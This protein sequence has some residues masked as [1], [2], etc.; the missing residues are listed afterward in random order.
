MKMKKVAAIILAVTTLCSVIPVQ[1]FAE[2]SVP[3]ESL[4]SEEEVVLTSRETTDT[5]GQCGENVTWTLTGEE[6]DLTLTISGSGYMW[7][8]VDIPYGWEDSISEISTII[9]ED[10]VTR[11]GY[12][13]FYGFANLT[14][15]TI[16]KTVTRIDGDA[17]YSCSSLNTVYYAGTLDEWAMIY[18]DDPL[19]EGVS[20]VYSDPGQVTLH[21][22]SFYT[23]YGTAPE[24]IEVPDGECI[25]VATNYDYSAYNLSDTEGYIF[26]GWS[27]LGEYD[28]YYQDSVYYESV[29]EDVE[30]HAVWTEGWAVEGIIEMGEPVV[31]AG[32]PVGSFH[33][34]YYSWG[35]GVYAEGEISETEAYSVGEEYTI[36]IHLL[37]DGAYYY[38][39]EG[40]N[41]VYLYDM[42]IGS[43]PIEPVS[44]S[45]TE[46]VVEFT[47]LPREKEQVGQVAVEGLSIMEGQQMGDANYASYNCNLGFEYQEG[48]YEADHEYTL[49]LHL[50]PY[51][52]QE[53]AN[54]GQISVMIN[55]EIAE[56]FSYSANEIVV[57]YS[58]TTPALI[59]ISNVELTLNGAVGDEI[60]GPYDTYSL[61]NE[62]IYVG[63]VGILW[64]DELEQ[65]DYYLENTAYPMYASLFANGGYSFSE[66]VT[67][68]V[69][70]QTATIDHDQSDSKHL[71]VTFEFTPEEPVTHEVSFVIAV[72]GVTAPDPI[73]V[74]QGMSLSQYAYANDYMSASELF[75]PECGMGQW[76]NG[77]YYDEEFTEPFDYD[78][79]YVLGDLTLYGSI[80][81]DY[82]SS[83]YT[84]S[85]NANGHGYSL[86]PIEIPGYYSLD[87]L[88][89][90]Y[91][92]IH[93]LA[94][95]YVFAGWSLDPEG[96][97]MLPKWE[98]FSD[99]FQGSHQVTLYAV[100]IDQM[101]EFTVT[102]NENG[103]GSAPASVTVN[104][105]SV[106]NDVIYYNG[107]NLITPGDVAGY[108]FDGWCLDEEGTVGVNGDEVILGNVT[109][110][111]HWIQEV[112]ITYDNM[113]HGETPDP[114]YTVPGWGWSLPSLNEDGYYFAGWYRWI[115]G[116]KVCD[117][118]Q[119]FWN[120]IYEDVTFY[121]EWYEIGD[122]VHVT[123][124]SDGHSGAPEDFDI[125]R[126]M[127]LYDYSGWDWSAYQ[128]EDD[129]ENGWVFDGW[130]EDSS[131]EYGD[132]SYSARVREDI[133]LYA[134]WREADP[135][136]WSLDSWTGYDNWEYY[137]GSPLT[138][139][140][141]FRYGDDRVCVTNVAFAED[142][143]DEVF[144]AGKTYALLI[145]MEPISDYYS[146]VTGAENEFS[147]WWGT[148]VE[149]DA[150]HVVVR[151]EFEPYYVSPESVSLDAI[152]LVLSVGD[153]YSL[154]ATVYPEVARYDSISWCSYGDALTV[155]DSGTLTAVQ[156]GTATVCVEVWLNNYVCAIAEYGVD[157]MPAEM[158]GTWGNL[159]WEYTGNLQEATLTIGGN[160]EMQPGY[161]DEG[162]DYPWYYDN[163]F[164]YNDWG[165]TRGPRMLHIVIEDGVTSVA[166]H[167]F[168]SDGTSTSPGINGHVVSLDL[169]DTLQHIGSYAFR[170]S[171]EEPTV[172]ELPNSLTSLGD[173][174]FEYGY[175]YGYTNDGNITGIHIPESVTEYGVGIYHG[176]PITDVQLNPGWTKITEG[177]FSNCAALE[178]VEVPEQI[179]EIGDLAFSEC[180]NLRTISL[181]GTLTSIGR[182]TF[183][184]CNNLETIYFDGTQKQWFSICHYLELPAGTEVICREIPVESIELN[185]TD[186]DIG[187]GQV[188]ELFATVLPADAEDP[189]VTWTTSNVN[190]ATVN[191]YGLVRGV[192]TGTTVI[193]ATANDGS[194]VSASCTVAVHG[195]CSVTYNLNRGSSSII[196]VRM[197]YGSEYGDTVPVS[198][199]GERFVGWFTD[200]E[201]GTEVRATDICTADITLY[202]HWI[203]TVSDVIS[204]ENT[205][206]GIRIT[207]TESSMATGYTI[208]R[209]TDDMPWKPLIGVY[210]T[211]E[212]VDTNVE[213]GTVYTYRV[214]AFSA[215]GAAENGV[216]MQ[217]TRISEPSVTATN[218][219]SGIMVSWLAVSGAEQYGVQ[220]R[221][222]NT[223]IWTVLAPVT[224]TS[225]TV[226]GSSLNSGTKYEFAVCAIAPDG[227]ESAFAM[228]TKQWVAAPSV[229]VSN[230][231]DGM[232]L[233]WPTVTG[234]AKYRVQYRQVGASSW[235]TAGTT[236][237]AS[238]LL[239]GSNLT[240]GTQYE[241]RVQAISSG[242]VYSSYI[243]VKKQWMAA[244]SATITI[245]A[246]GINLSWP[247]VAGA[248]KYRVQ[249][250]Q[251]GASSWTT[252]GT[253]K[254]TL[255]TVGS[256]NLTSGTQYEFRVQAISSGGVYSSSTTIKKQW[257]AAP[258][259][260]A[261]NI[262][263]GINL[264]WGA[265]TG[266]AKYRVQYRQVGASSWTTAG[267]TTSTSYL[268]AGSNLT[269]GTQYEIRV[270]A[271]SSG[272]VYSSCTV[273]KKQW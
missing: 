227:T 62:N 19:P 195:R 53:F 30:L 112:M 114:I 60:N 103:H 210:D 218:T 95:G 185:V 175:Y 147:V 144:Q 127:S 236:T 200:A 123:F 115:D 72:E 13:A 228:A 269:S 41:D 85:F 242:G 128:M 166:D 59:E 38:P 58:L 164:G 192:S 172:L 93:M 265:I 190:V 243:S 120:P 207:W 124:V 141:N 55:G 212:Y 37:T 87:T 217:A 22:V 135:I 117:N 90:E 132:Y 122:T 231:A 256:S 259:V 111:A 194:G 76:F 40:S 160:G 220:Y 119:A 99:I 69:N 108:Y 250:R 157:V 181:P 23:E 105:G 86:A 5:S 113:G 102:Y 54:D 237:S 184:G 116:V 9:I 2:E 168:V 224:D 203:P 162:Y 258:V 31:Y 126:G 145:T 211:T 179:T 223:E 246:D 106:Y 193:T 21:T 183:S 110:Y 155:D 121:A 156:P 248:A 247:A 70:G 264:S 28:P 98:N 257:M 18:M 197:D 201:A 158:S 101:N 167:A 16:P 177:M 34:G 12:C 182:R 142:Y 171:F 97:S 159:T 249:Y 100:W 174:P 234:A 51:E 221:P 64:T 8:H 63:G 24:P 165:T 255:Y 150:D 235:T 20:V 133:T 216:S 146:F 136:I 78:S 125:Q 49:A 94:D 82:Y 180:D 188:L 222:V 262:T 199:D 91:G 71:Y 92:S 238:Y 154:T 36:R 75:D 271:I 84:I 26:S 272:N 109:L 45:R 15:V 215:N 42:E 66:D 214:R 266:A 187:I 138:L 1:A 39:G 176:L 261:S 196:T 7:G 143:E 206:T 32:E 17:F 186:G 152:G 35:M 130:S 43:I 33:L 107:W 189:T 169:P 3:D 270:Q 79:S 129:Y 170:L 204:V 52:G 153:T 254:G 46:I 273:V 260:T 225:Y 77:W 178:E 68:V 191:S 96:T 139:P 137:I 14:T 267:T 74:R 4:A 27:G 251:V 81:E 134:V 88:E 104:A 73:Q 61:S 244:P 240:S 263:S 57:Y 208:Y 198:V 163:V 118:E 226:P 50:T 131:A 209:M 151:Y 232:N 44:R 205:E 253:T 65:T 67:L 202:A 161:T 148:V 6:N 11:I 80:G 48:Y 29:Y 252:A 140:E 268:L 25:A 219:A 149:R 230:M 89:W 233:S 241:F 239:V 213:P 83:T 229:T 56:P 47:V 173:W 245:A 10:G